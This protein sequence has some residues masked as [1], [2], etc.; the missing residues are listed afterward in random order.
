[1]TFCEEREKSEKGVVGMRHRWKSAVLALLLAGLV[2]F[3]LTGCELEEEATDPSGDNTTVSDYEDSVSTKTV[4]E[5]SKKVSRWVVTRTYTEDYVA[6]QLQKS[7]DLNYCL[8]QVEV[9]ALADTTD[10]IK[11]V[12]LLYALNANTY[13]DYLVEYTSAENE[14]KKKDDT[15]DRR[16]VLVTFEYDRC[17]QHYESHGVEPVKVTLQ[18]GTETS[19]T[20]TISKTICKTTCKMTNAEDSDNGEKS[21]SYVEDESD[22]ALDATLSSYTAQQ[23]MNAAL[24]LALGQTTTTSKNAKTT[25]FED[26]LFDLADS[27]KEYADAALRATKA[28]RYPS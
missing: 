27:A 8:E 25:T 24:R 6:D 11:K 3:S 23:V 19:K 10:E 1:V 20:D 13:F 15:A 26:N 18:Y 4:E 28:S 17:S 16:Y 22:H 14:L 21:I 5:D 9:E 7:K 2:C 12:S